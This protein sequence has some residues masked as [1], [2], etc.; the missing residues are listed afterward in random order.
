MQNY[1]YDFY[2]VDLNAIGFKIAF[3]VENFFNRLGYDDPTYV[4]WKVGMITKNG[5]VDDFI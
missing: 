1:Y 5:G 4:Q 2:V 3:A